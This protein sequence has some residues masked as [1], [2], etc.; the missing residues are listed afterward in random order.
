[1]WGES[2]QDYCYGK[3]PSITLKV[4]ILYIECTVF[5]VRF[6]FLRC[7]VNLSHGLISSTGR[8]GV[9]VKAYFVFL[10]YLLFLNF[11]NCTIIAGSVL[12]PALYIRTKNTNTSCKYSYVLSAEDFRKSLLVLFIN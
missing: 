11:L 5:R 3:P 10:R 9:G 12:S 1:M 7:C 4:Y 6:V 8:F 2:S